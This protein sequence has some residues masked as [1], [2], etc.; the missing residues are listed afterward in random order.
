LRRVWKSKKIKKASKATTATLPITIP[1]IGP[2]PNPFFEPLEAAVV[3][4]VGAAKVEEAVVGVFVGAKVV[5]W[6]P[7][8]VVVLSKTDTV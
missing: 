2:P 1:A 4:V 6:P 3:D 7:P 8:L 5:S